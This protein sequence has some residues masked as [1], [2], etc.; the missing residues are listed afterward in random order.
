[1]TKEDLLNMIVN[2][3]GFVLSLNR[4]S[5]DRYVIKRP[6]KNPS[7]RT[8]YTFISI[9]DEFVKVEKF[10]EILLSSPMMFEK[11][12]TIFENVKYCGSHAS[13]GTPLSNTKIFE[14]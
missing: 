12:T 14:N 13:V 1:M 6:S 9:T 3:F 4:Y 11:L 10:D 8:E 7:Y 2:E 5:R